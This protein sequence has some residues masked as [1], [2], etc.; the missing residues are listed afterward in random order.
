MASKKKI[1]RTKKKSVQ[2]KQKKRAVGKRTSMKPPKKVKKKLSTR[3]RSTKVNATSKKVK[4]KLTSRM[5][6]AKAKAKP[7]KVKKSV[8]KTAKPTKNSLTRKS[9]ATTTELSNRPERRNI[10]LLEPKYQNKYPPIGLMKIATYHKMLGDNV[11]FFKGEV[12]DLVVEQLAEACIKKLNR[13]DKKDWYGVFTQIS[14]FIKTRDQESFEK[15]LSIKTRY[16]GLIANCLNSFAMIYKKKDYEN[17]PKWDR[18]YVTTLFT[19]YWKVTVETIHQAKKLVKSPD[20]VFVGGVLASLLHKELETETGLKAHKGL[21]DHAGMLDPNIPIAKD[22]IIDNLPL[23]YSILDEISYKYPTGSAY[24]TFMTKGC[25]RK[26]AFCSVPI[27]EPTYKPKIETIDKF[28]EINTKYGEQQHLLLMDNNV[29]ASPNFPEI[30]AEIKAMGFHKG[31]T[32][33][34]PNQLDIAIKNLKEGW[35]DKAYLSRIH[36]LLN[37]LIRRVKG[38]NQQNYYDVL[39]KNNLL[40]LET[41]TRAGVLNAY[42]EVKNVYERYR[43]KSPRQ[44]YVDFNQGTDARYVTDDLMRL[45]S[46]IPIRPLRIAFDY[47]GM[48]EKYENAVRLAGKYG[49]KQLS[50]Y[51]L[52]NF[53]DSPEE[54]YKRLEINVL[55]SN[56]LDIEIYSFPMKYIPLFGEDAKHRDFIGN[57]WNRKF[58]RAIQSVLNVTKGI[59]ASGHEFFEKAFGK[60]IDEFFEILHMPETYIIYRYF[61]EGNG[62][63][64]KWR[65]LYRSLNEEELVIAN[66]IIRSNNFKEYESNVSNPKILEL[67]AHYK[68]KKSEVKEIENLDLGYKETKKKAAK[69]IKEDQFVDLTLTYDFEAPTIRKKQALS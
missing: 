18:I 43:N 58:I 11:K 33:V 44:R 29:L 65:E 32:F 61:F 40:K 63:T 15:V 46:E 1:S 16:G 24:F 59:V 47:W 19:F 5:G 10:L 57:K 67:L 50:N 25:T 8:K 37:D 54:L 26:C 69:L 56:E 35:N 41:T 13:I 48:R 49:I 38:G 45:M 28:K 23:D 20:Q 68:V 27:L 36:F 30:I 12:R 7:K 22:I 51:I 64:G 6:F 2:K 52:Y 34:E 55:L 62:M 17:Y 4:K 53:K 31:A 21:L 60:T 3:K 66:E 39:E 14:S 42:K 9:R